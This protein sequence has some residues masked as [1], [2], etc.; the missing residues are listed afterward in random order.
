VHDVWCTAGGGWLGEGL[1]VEGGEGRRGG[2][3]GGRVEHHYR[4]LE[5]SF[6]SFYP[7]LTIHLE[8]CYYQ[9]LPLG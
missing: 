6:V 9:M 4:V 1:G 5:D 7:P 2:R 8:I 3:D